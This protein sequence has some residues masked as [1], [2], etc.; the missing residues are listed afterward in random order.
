MRKN[1]DSSF[2]LLTWLLNNNNIINILFKIKMGL[3]Q[4]TGLSGDVEG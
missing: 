2:Q 4:I 1:V 3:T